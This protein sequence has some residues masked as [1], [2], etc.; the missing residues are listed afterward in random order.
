MSY[1][2]YSF[3]LVAVGLSSSLAIAQ[4]ANGLDSAAGGMG[5]VAAERADRG[6]SV[7]H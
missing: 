1:R 5:A 6:Q 7:I 3:I 2:P 4:V